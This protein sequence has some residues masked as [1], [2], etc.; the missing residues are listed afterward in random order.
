MEVVP[1]MVD[2]GTDTDTEMAEPLQDT[3]EHPDRRQSGR[4][5]RGTCKTQG[6]LARR[7]R[8]PRIRTTRHALRETS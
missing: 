2:M 4:C 6:R 3:W 7:L 8:Q 5:L 1:L